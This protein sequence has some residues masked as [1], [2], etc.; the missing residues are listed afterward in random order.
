MI[1]NALDVGKRDKCKQRR[2]RREVF[3]FRMEDK[4][5]IFVDLSD[6]VAINYKGFCKVGLLF[7][8]EM[9]SR[10]NETPR[11]KF[12]I[13][14]LF[15]AHNSSL[16]RSIQGLHIFPSEYNSIYNLAME[17]PKNVV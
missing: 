14:S 9:G 17:S 16:E 4:E 5:E 2:R 15:G 13:R 7:F 6:R 3:G 10:D 11:H 8:K 12:G 1:S